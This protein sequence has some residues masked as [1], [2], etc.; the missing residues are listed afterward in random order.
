MSKYCFAW[1][2]LSHSISLKRYKTVCI[3]C[4]SLPKIEFDHIEIIVPKNIQTGWKAYLKSEKGEP[5]SKWKLNLEGISDPSWRL[6]QNALVPI[7]YSSTKSTTTYWRGVP[8]QRFH[9][10]HQQEELVWASM[11][12]C[13]IRT[14]KSS[15]RS[16]T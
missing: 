13:S 5:I 7:K 9:Q 16:R 11:L 8:M 6:A 4:Q 15:A 10:W 14:K 12:L 1:I 2:L 3:F